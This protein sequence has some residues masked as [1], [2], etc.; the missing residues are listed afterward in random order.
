MSELKLNIQKLNILNPSINN[1]NICSNNTLNKG[2][3]EIL[4]V[5]DKEEDLFM[6]EAKSYVIIV[7]NHEILSRTT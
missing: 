5:E 3:V 7:G 4:E 1:I 2:G 6:K